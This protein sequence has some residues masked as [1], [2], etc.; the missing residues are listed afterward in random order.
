VVDFPN[1][2]FLRMEAANF[3]HFVF[4]TDFLAQFGYN[5]GPWCGHL[6]GSMMVRPAMKKARGWEGTEGT[7]GPLSL[8]LLSSPE[9]EWWKWM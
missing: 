3:P 5:P 9:F 8:S 7:S 2:L 4:H 6:R 1:I